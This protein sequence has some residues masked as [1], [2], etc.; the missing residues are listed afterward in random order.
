MRDASAPASIGAKIASLGGVEGSDLGQRR[1]R[2]ES[3]VGEARHAV[4]PLSELARI[5]SAPG[6]G[7]FAQ[8]AGLF[9]QSAPAASAWPTRGSTRIAAATE[10]NQARDR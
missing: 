4:C 3:Q 10:D 6:L 1:M 2:E 5:R 9:E 7:A 8:L